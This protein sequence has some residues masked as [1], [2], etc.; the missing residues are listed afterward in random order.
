MVIGNGIGVA[1]FGTTGG[2][3]SFTMNG[4]I[5]IDRELDFDT[6]GQT[7]TITINGA[8][9]GAGRLGNITG[10]PVIILN[11]SNSFSG[12]VVT[13]AQFFAGDDNAFGSGT[14]WTGGFIGAYGGPRTIAN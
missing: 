1:A 14:L 13:S 3:H 4:N 5:A 12:G 11:H 2:A 9:S 10:N 7:S 8:I 6:A